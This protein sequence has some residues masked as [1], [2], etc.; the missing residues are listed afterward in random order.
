MGERSGAQGHRGGGC[1][2]SR[3]RSRNGG[4]RIKEDEG[5]EAVK[6]Q[7]KA[8]VNPKSPRG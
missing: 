6:R 3:P 7:V 8:W 4:S 2:A 5:L 1:V